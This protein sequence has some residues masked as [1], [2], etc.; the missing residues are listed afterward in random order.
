MTCWKTRDLK[1]ISC[2]VCGQKPLEVHVSKVNG[3]QVFT[4]ERDCSSCNPP[5][6]T[7]GGRAA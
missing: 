1:D 3:E 5:S 6:A 4:C 7:P 2:K